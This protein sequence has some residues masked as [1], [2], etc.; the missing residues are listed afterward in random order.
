ME[1]D[2]QFAKALGFQYLVLLHA[3]GTA[4]KFFEK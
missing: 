2:V 3:G 4:A 1:T